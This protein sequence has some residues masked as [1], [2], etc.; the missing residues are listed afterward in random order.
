MI[1]F[2]HLLSLSD[3]FDVLI[4]GEPLPRGAVYLEQKQSWTKESIGAVLPDRYVDTTNYDEIEDRPAFAKRHNLFWILD[5]DTV[6]DIVYNAQ[7]QLGNPS[8]EQL[9]DAFNFYWKHD[10][11][12]E[13]KP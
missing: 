8:I 7:L 2:E 3:L 10:G 4:T 1:Q 6:E 9:V 13:F 5:T 11:F 12:L